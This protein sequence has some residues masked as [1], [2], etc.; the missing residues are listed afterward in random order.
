MTPSA[1]KND[2]IMY[3]GVEKFCIYKIG[4]AKMQMGRGPGSSGSKKQ[5][6][7]QPWRQKQRR[8][9]KLQQ[10]YNKGLVKIYIFMYNL[11]IGKSAFR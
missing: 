7:R 6:P 9:Q 4:L 3:R 11:K 10:P 1:E 5:Q 8:R 2:K